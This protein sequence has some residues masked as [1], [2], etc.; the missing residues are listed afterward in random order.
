MSEANQLKELNMKHK[1]LARI[2]TGLGFRLVRANK[3]EVWSNGVLT[4]CLPRHKEINRNLA[5]K[6]LRDVGVNV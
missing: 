4:V 3:H 1:E 6:I 5:K 2:L